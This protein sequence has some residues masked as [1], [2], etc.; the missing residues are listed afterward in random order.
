MTSASSIFPSWSGLLV[1]FAYC[2]APAPRFILG[3]RLV[4]RFGLTVLFQPAFMCLVLVPSMAFSRSSHDFAS[5][6]VL[7]W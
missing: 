1:I 2:P 4:G 5:V 6:I 7:S 3:F